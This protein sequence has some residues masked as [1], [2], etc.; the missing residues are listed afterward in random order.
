MSK[1]KIVKV[2]GGLQD[3]LLKGFDSVIDARNTK[4]KQN[5]NGVDVEVNYLNID[6]IPCKG[7]LGDDDF[8]SIRDCINDA[9]ANIQPGP[10]D[11]TDT[12][13]VKL[14]VFSNMDNFI[15]TAG[16]SIVLKDNEIE[17]RHNG[18]ENIDLVD[19]K[20]IA[21]KNV[22]AIYFN[23]LSIPFIKDDAGAYSALIHIAAA[24]TVYR[25]DVRCL[26]EV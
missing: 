23:E 14:V 10:P 4:V 18:V 3:L 6:T 12:Q 16:I 15:P 26:V 5:R 1:C 17:L 13:E 22:I 8:K 11:S 21:A 2:L 9:I 19:T 20:A 7:S 25:K 24:D